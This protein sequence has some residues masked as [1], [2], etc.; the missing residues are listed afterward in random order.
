[1]KKGTY[2]VVTTKARGVFAGTLASVPSQEKVTL[3]GARMCIRWA[4]R[5]GVFGLAVEGPTDACKIG[6]R[7]GGESIFY[8]ITGIAECSTAARKAWDSK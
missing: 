1:M 7:V 4:S 8:S 3:T 6:A 2:V 5:S